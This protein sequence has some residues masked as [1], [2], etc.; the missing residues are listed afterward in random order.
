M[1]DLVSAAKTL[2]ALGDDGNALRC[3]E[4]DPTEVQ[5]M[6]LKKVGK[7]AGPVVGMF[8]MGLFEYPRRKQKVLLDAVYAAR[9]QLFAANGRDLFFRRSNE[10]AGGV[11]GLEQSVLNRRATDDGVGADVTRGTLAAR[12]MGIQM[13]RE[14]GLDVSDDEDLGNTRFELTVVGTNVQQEPRAGGDAA[15]VNRAP[16]GVVE[17]PVEMIGGPGGTGDGGWRWSKVAHR[18]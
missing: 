5:R 14:Y 7:A 12:R 10:G 9:M 15:G 2:K 16:A 4:A 6:A 3:V 13:L 1:T 17:M 18:D 8:V 11:G